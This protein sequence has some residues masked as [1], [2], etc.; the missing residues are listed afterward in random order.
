ML[1]DS[2]RGNASTPLFAALGETI[3]RRSLSLAPFRDLLAA[4]KQDLAVDR[5]ENREELFGYCRLS[6]N[7]IGR[8]VLAVC[9]YSD[10]Q[11]FA[12]S[13]KICTALQLANHWQ[14]V[15]EDFARG[16]IYVPQEIIRA[17]CRDESSIRE[18]DPTP[19]FRRMMLH[20][21]DMAEGLFVE[22][23]P[24]VGL[25]GKPL[26][27]QLYLYY[28]GGM[29]ALEA[30]RKAGGDVI[31]RRCRVSSANRLKLLAGAMMVWAGSS[32]ASN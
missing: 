21:C 27:P 14:D 16:R 30:I 32:V 11:Y 9:G 20:L 23:K 12:Y 19:E 26:A 17:F 6:A 29:A 31:K 28:G 7:P 1:E 22:G 25:V 8:L 18:N 2:A 13:D 15:S 3:H 24:L 5:Y 4:F 10:E